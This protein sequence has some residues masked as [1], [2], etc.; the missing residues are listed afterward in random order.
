MV[1][2]STKVSD[3]LWALSVLGQGER[4][5]DISKGVPGGL[6]TLTPDFADCSVGG[7]LTV[8]SKVP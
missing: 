2:V 7:M 8:G 6:Y 1:G 5:L 3:V 4:R